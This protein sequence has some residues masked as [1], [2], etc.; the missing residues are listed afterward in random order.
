MQYPIQPTFSSYVSGAANIWVAGRRNISPTQSHERA[1][2]PALICATLMH[3]MPIY[4]YECL[5]G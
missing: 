5:E 4:P 2:P 1:S 3:D